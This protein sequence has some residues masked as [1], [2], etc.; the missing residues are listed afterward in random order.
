[1]MLQGKR[2]GLVVQLNTSTKRITNTYLT[3]KGQAILMV[4]P[5]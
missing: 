2:S 4:V 3:Q 1:M 5:F